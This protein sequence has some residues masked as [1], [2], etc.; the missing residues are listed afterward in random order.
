L[1]SIREEIRMLREFKKFALYG[2][3]PDMAV[4]II[5]G[6][7]CDV[8][9]VRFVAIHPADGSKSTYRLN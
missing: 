7:A 5:I 8:R 1:I 4:G 3:M 9:P 6:A 2:N